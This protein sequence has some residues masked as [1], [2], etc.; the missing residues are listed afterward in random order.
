MNLHNHE[1]SNFMEVRAVYVKL[2]VSPK[3]LTIFLQACHF[4]FQCK[5]TALGPSELC[6]SESHSLRV[7]NTFK[8]FFKC[9]HCS[10][11]TITLDL[12]P[13]EVCRNCG[14]SRWERAPMLKVS[15]S[16]DCTENTITLL[17]YPFLNAQPPV[18][19]AQKMPFF[20]PVH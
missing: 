10:K 4:Y 5:Y 6:K 9:G 17:L 3:L 13:L 14:M 1:N 15:D 20:Q 8:R 18:W 16:K 19:T 11:R 7:V 12:V 2:S